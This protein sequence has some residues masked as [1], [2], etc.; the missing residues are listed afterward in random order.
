[1]NAA[2]AKRTDEDLYVL[3][4]ACL[5]LE[6]GCNDQRNNYEVKPQGLMVGG[7]DKP[8]PTGCIHNIFF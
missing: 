8:K 6:C 7:S 2:A 1:M 3:C 5:R 4:F